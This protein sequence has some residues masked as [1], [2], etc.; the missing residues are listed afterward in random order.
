MREEEEKEGKTGTERYTGKMMD[1][2]RQKKIW[3]GSQRDLRVAWAAGDNVESSERQDSN[4][5]PFG[6]KEKMD[7]LLR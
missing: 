2:H 4:A 6:Q 7:R 5:S 1:K 3:L